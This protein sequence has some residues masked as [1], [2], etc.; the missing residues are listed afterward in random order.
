[1]FQPWIRTTVAQQL[2]VLAAPVA[3]SALDGWRRE[4]LDGVEI[5][6]V[7]GSPIEP[8]RAHARSE[9]ERGARG[10][11]AWAV[12]AARGPVSGSGTAF[13]RRR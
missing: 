1:M 2:A 10:G 9:R 12:L 6:L 8:E 4:P 5:T 3:A 13:G 11:R 7:W